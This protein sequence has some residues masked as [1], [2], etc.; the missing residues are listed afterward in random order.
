LATCLLRTLRLKD[1]ATLSA[2]TDEIR[3]ALGVGA[4]ILPMSDDPVRTEIISDGR[5]LGFQE[6]F[7]KQR[8]QP[9]VDE[10]VLTGIADAKPAPGVL[11]AIPEAECVVLCPSNPIVSIGPILALPGIREALRQHPRVIAV[12]PIIQGAPVKGPADKMLAAVGS[13]VSASGVASLYSDFCDLFV[14]DSSDPDE[15]ERVQNLG[16]KPLLLDTMMTDREASTRLARSLL[17]S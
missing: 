3:R 11:D 5:R 17:A 1:G 12:T 15:F 13:E 6:Y 14:I 4:R 10:I 8:H 2:V 9:T 7:V 16:I